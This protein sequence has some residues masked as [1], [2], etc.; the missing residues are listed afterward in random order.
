MASAA[1]ATRPWTWTARSDDADD[2]GGG[3]GGGEAAG[4]TLVLET[5]AAGEETQ[6]EVVVEQAEPSRETWTPAKVAAAQA[7]SPRT[8]RRWTRSRRSCRQPP[9]GPPTSSAP[10]GRGTVESSSPGPS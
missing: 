7:P 2:G 1:T 10:W 3:D 5:P 9:A 6:A 4:T 8:G